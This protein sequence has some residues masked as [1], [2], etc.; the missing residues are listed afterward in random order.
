[1]SLVKYKINLFLIVS[2]FFMALFS[3][4]VDDNS[5]YN[6]VYN[7]ENEAIVKEVD[8]S[9]KEE[10]V[11]DKSDLML[12]SNRKWIFPVEGNYV[13]TTYYGY[14]HQAIDIYGYNGYGSN[15]LAANSGYV[16]G[17]YGGCVIGNLRCNG[18]GGN[19]I[20]IKHDNNFYSVYMHLSSI[21]V[22]TGDNV[23]FGQYIGTMGNTGNVI[24][25]PNSTNPY[26]GTHLHF[27]IYV[28]E[29]YKGGYAI[30][31]LTKY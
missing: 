24:P 19:Y 15:I 27:A 8:T 31:P 25:V 9:I 4:I 29:P 3:L 17:V 1:M 26:L 30:N 5:L 18:G 16:V 7:F 20:I 10:I 13:I 12:V 22:K 14:G 23:T 21:K 11:L 28:G 2:S 6:Y